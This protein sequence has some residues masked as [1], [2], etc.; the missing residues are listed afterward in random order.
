MS[1]AHGTRIPIP[2]AAGL[3]AVFAPVPTARS[4][5]GCG[6]NSSQWVGKK[7]LST[8]RRLI[9]YWMQDQMA[10]IGALVECCNFA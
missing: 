9:P 7:R 2:S 1:V 5:C 8:S 10:I 3:S 4:V 6:T